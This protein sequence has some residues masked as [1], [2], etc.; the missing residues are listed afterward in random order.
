MAAGNFT[1]SQL[2]EVRLKAEQMWT[3]SQLAASLKP[4]AEAARAV[5][6]HQTARFDVLN[7]T[8]KDRVVKV[9]FIDACGVQATD[10]TATCDI[11]GTELSTGAKEY[12]A[13]LCQ[14][15]SFSVNVTKLRTNDYG[16][17][18]VVAQGLAAAVKALDEWWAQKVLA[19]IKTFAGVNVAPAPF[20]YDA[21][22]KTTKFTDL[23]PAV[24]RSNLQLLANFVQQAKLNRIANPYIIDNGTFFVD[25]LNA[26]FDSGNAEG[27]GYAARL[28]AFENMLYDDQFNFAAAG[29]TDS[30]FMVGSGAVAFKTVNKHPDTP[31]LIGGDV[32]ETIYTIPSNALPNV[33]YDVTYTIKCV[34]TENVKEYVHVWELKTHGLV[35]LNP[36]G[37]P[38]NAVV[39]GEATVVTPS[40]VLSYTKVAPVAT[41]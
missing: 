30:L 7:D 31:T 12:K 21:T 39:N 9:T 5:L 36:E 37:C 38:V 20:I 17:S 8:E 15:A 22:A 11:T 4:E 32:Q 35:E 33:K 41:D 24:Y 10:C 16:S 1:P 23:D 40:G 28:R 34:V 3:D 13:N 19:K 25:M 2:L 26:A 29:L 27:K 14:Q 18:E 6:E